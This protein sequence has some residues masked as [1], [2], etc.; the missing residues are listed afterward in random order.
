MLLTIIC[1][2]GI[3]RAFDLP[4]IYYCWDILTSVIGIQQKHLLILRWSASFVAMA[5]LVP[6]LVFLEIRLSLLPWLP[7][8]LALYI[9]III[10][11]LQ[12]HKVII[13]NGILWMSTY[14]TWHFWVSCVV[15]KVRQFMHKH[16]TQYI[17]ILSLDKMQIG[18]KW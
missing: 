2:N 10:C 18:M 13:T 14:I 15:F 16:A 5:L 3:L 8:I 4:V 1:L 9:S 12:R 7:L 11:H 17:S 6:F